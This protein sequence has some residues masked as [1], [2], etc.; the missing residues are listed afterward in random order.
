MIITLYTIFA[1][2]TF[3]WLIHIEKKNGYVE[4]GLLV[5]LTL[6]SILW[7]VTGVCYLIVRGY[8]LLEGVVNK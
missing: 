5:F 3:L 8:E 7:P 6:I 1:V 2:I 4:K